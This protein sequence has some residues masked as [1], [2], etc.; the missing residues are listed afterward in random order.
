L[1][2]QI[3]VPHI[4]P[5][6]NRDCVD[7]GVKGRF[8]GIRCVVTSAPAD[9][10]ELTPNRRNAHM[11]N[12][13]LRRWVRRINLPGFNLRKCRHNEYGNEQDSKADEPLAD[14]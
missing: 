3:V 5:S 4:H 1:G 9:L 7:R 13:E 8:A 6:V 12:S 14:Q 10:L 2:A 11:T